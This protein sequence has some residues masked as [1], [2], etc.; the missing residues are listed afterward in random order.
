M[1]TYN[2]SGDVFY[3]WVST[4]T[5]SGTNTD[6]YTN[7]VWESWTTTDSITGMTSTCYTDGVWEEW[8]QK[9]VYVAEPTPWVREVTTAE[10]RRARGA[11]RRIDQIERDR[12]M[13]EEE[14][15]KR[16][17]EVTAQ[18]LLEDLIGES[19]LTLYNETKRLV[20]KGRKYDYVIRKQG[21]VYKIEKGKVIDLCIHLKRQYTYPE[22]DNVIALKILIEADEREF[23]KT[24]NNQGELRNEVVKKEM[25]KLVAREVAV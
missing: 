17:A 9:L 15:R 20:V 22:T 2:T 3:Q 5:S 7:S 18:E 13:S 19:A 10:Q 11:Q 25:L 23:L 24:A 16:L 12:K 6:S 14:E 8:T 4:P 1:A 21:G